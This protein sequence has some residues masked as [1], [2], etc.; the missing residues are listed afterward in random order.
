MINIAIIP[1]RAGSKR[2]K[3]KNIKL[4]NKKPI[5]SYVL[6]I[7]KKSKNFKH[8]VVTSDSKK[9]LN[10][11]KKHNADILI[12]RPKKFSN[13]FVGT[14]AVIVHAINFLKKK[15]INFDNVFCTYPTSIFLNKKIIKEAIKKKSQKGYVI[16]ATKFKHPIERSFRKLKKKISVNFPKYLN[17]RTQDITESFHDAGQFYFASKKVWI[18]QKKIISNK[19][20][21]IEIPQNSSHDIDTIED[22]KTAEII[23]KNIN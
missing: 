17:Y 20:T 2:I 7:L 3:N 4:F 6:K 13:D 10:I 22:W 14:H 15:K 23:W 8:I 5:V 9:I 11:C 18:N 21:F 12:N 1:A 16:S 19:S